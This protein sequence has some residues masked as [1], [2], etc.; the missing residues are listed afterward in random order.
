MNE[1]SV[2]NVTRGH[3]FYFA[4]THPDEAPPDDGWTFRCSFPH[5]WAI[6][7]RHGSVPPDEIRKNVERYRWIRKA[8]AWES[9][10]GMDALSEDPEKF[11]AAVDEAMRDNP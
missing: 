9:E 10:I 5:A 7:V 8:G 2:E 1:M 6:W 4:M 3:V 11:D